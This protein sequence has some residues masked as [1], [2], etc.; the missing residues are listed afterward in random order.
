MSRAIRDCLAID[1][2]G[3]RSLFAAYSAPQQAQILASHQIQSPQVVAVREIESSFVEI[4]NQN[5]NL[6]DNQR[7]DVALGAAVLRPAGLL[8]IGRSDAL[9]VQLRKVV[10]LQVGFIVDSF[11]DLKQLDV[12]AV[13]VDVLKERALVVADHLFN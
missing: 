6:V 2:T 3:R 13:Q 11:V 1:H 12:D 8:A 7:I 9:R 10:V 5:V 4:A